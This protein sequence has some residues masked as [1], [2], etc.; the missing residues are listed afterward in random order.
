[1]ERY[2]AFRSQSHN[3][4]K[5]VTL[6][7][8][9]SRLIEECQL[10]DVSHQEQAL[11]CHDDHTAQHRKL[12]ATIRGGHIKAADKLRL[13]LLY[14]LRYE[15]NANISA[16]KRE[17]IDGG[18]AE[19]KVRMIDIVLEKCGKAKRAPGLYGDGNFMSRMSKNLSTSLAGVEN[20]NIHYIYVLKK[21]ENA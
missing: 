15:D 14:V 2:P 6:M 17:L 20:V 8:E 13:A 1:M 19:E 9:L 18:V 7:T 16:L 10:L 21:K 3:V 11:A 5:H 12:L 4:T